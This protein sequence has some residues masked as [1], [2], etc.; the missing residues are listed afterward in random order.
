MITSRRRSIA[1]IL[2]ATG[3]VGPAA[4]AAAALASGVPSH[5]D[6]IGWFLAFQTSPYAPLQRFSLGLLGGLTL[7]FALGMGLGEVRG[8]RHS[9]AGP[10]AVGALGALLL[11]SALV[12]DSQGQFR[13]YVA[14]ASFLTYPA[15]VA[16]PFAVWWSTRKDEEWDLES[17]VSLTA[18]SLL[19][20]VF[21]DLLVAELHPMIPSEV[22]AVTS[23]RFA[24]AFVGV[25][26]LWLES[27]AVKHLRVA[28][29]NQLLGPP[30]ESGPTVSPS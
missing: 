22:R 12:P 20:L 25:L 27:L 15:A 28:R 23:T 18:G 4:F 10:T 14:F 30:S 1:T 3:L 2:L 29:R 26:L 11:W 24:T 7:A 13:A 16:A 21:L 8:R 9:L 17:S 19:L 5:F 6:G